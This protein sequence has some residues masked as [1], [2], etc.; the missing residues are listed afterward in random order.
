[1]TVEPSSKEGILRNTNEKNWFLILLYQS[2]LS[3]SLL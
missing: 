1:M 2:L 3:D